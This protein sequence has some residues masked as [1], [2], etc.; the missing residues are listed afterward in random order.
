MRLTA[1]F[2]RPA[3]LPF[4]FALPLLLPIGC[5]SGSSSSG[6]TS[7]ATNTQVSG[8]VGNGAGARPAAR[9]GFFGRAPRPAA[10]FPDAIVEALDSDGNVVASTTTDAAGDYTIS[11]PDGT[12]RLGV[13][14][15]SISSFVPLRSPI[16]VRN[17]T[18]DGTT[19]VSGRATLDFE[20]PDASTT[21]TG[22]VTAS[23]NPV[24]DVN[25][26]FVD[27]E[28]QEVRFS[29]A[30]NGS[31]AFSVS[32]IPVGNF[33]VR[34]A[35]STI[36]TG[37]AAPSARSL[38]VTSGGATPSNFALT[39]PASTSLSGSVDTTN[40][41][42]L[43]LGAAPVGALPVPRPPQRANLV[44][45]D[46]AEVVIIEI[47]I[48]E[49]DRVDMDT[50]GSYVLN[51]RDGSYRLEFVGFGSEVVAPPPLRITVKNGLVYV[52]GQD[53]PIDPS[54]A[55]TLDVLAFDVTASVRG[56]VTVAGSPVRTRVFA[57]DVSTKGVV[58][59]ADT[60]ATGAYTISLADGSYNLVIDDELLPPG[61]IPPDAVRVSIE[62]D[63]NNNT[64][65]REEA[66]TAN[67]GIVNFAM[68]VSSVTLTGTVEDSSQNA[69]K[70]IRVIA[71]KKGERVGRAV[72]TSA[73]AYSLQLPLG[74]VQVGISQESA[75]SG[76]SAP[77]PTVLEVALVNGS[78]VIT[79]SAGEISTLDFTLESRSNNVSGTITF[80]FN[81]DDT[82][83]ANEVVGCRIIVGQPNSKEIVTSTNS[84]PET[85]AY[86]LAVK[87]GAYLI[88]LHPDSLPPGSAP[89]SPRRISVDASGVTTS[90]GTTAATATLD[91]RLSRRASTL[92]GVVT[93]D[94]QAISAGLEL[95]DLS[96]E[97]VAGRARSDSITGIYRLPIFAGRYELR[98]D[99]TTLP[100]GVA[101]PSPITLSATAAGVV[102]T[103]DGTQIDFNDPNN[104]LGVSFPLTR[105]VATLTGAVSV[106]RGSET[107]FVETA[108]EVRDPQDHGVLFSTSSLPG[109]GAYSLKLGAGIWEIGLDPAALPPGVLPPS[110]QVVLVSGTTV[111]GDAV[112]N[113]TLSFVIRD[114]RQAGAAISGLVYGAVSEQGV[115]A[116]LRLFDPKVGSVDEN[117]ILSIRT[118]ED[119][120]YSFRA[121][122]GTYK[123]AVLPDSLPP[124]A[125]PPTSVQLAVRNVNNTATVFETSEAE[126]SGGT[127]NEAD[128]GTINFPIR[129]GSGATTG[130]SIA[131]TVTET[132]GQ[133]SVPLGGVSVRVRDSST[134]DTVARVFTEFGTGTYALR[135]PLGSY[136]LELNP[137]SLPFHLIPRAP[138]SILA[139]LQS[140]V[141]VV[142]TDNGVTVTPNNGVYTFD[143][144]PISA[145][146]T[147]SGT[148]SLPDS[149]AARVFVEL[150]ERSDGRFILGN[151][152]DSAN[153]AYRMQVAP[154]SYRLGID[155][156]SLP[157]G[158]TAPSSVE[159]SVTATA[160]LE[161]SGTA[162]DGTVNF[163]LKSANQKIVGTITDASQEPLACYINVEDAISGKFI[164]GEPT[165]PVTGTYGISVPP[166]TYRVFIDANSLPPGFAP[167]APVKAQV[168][169]GSNFTVDFQ[170]KSDSA[171]IVGDVRQT[172]A[173]QTPMPVFMILED[174]S[175]GQF[176]KGEPNDHE[177]GA[178]K[179]CASDGSYK[180]LVAPESVPF[181]MVV[182]SPVAVQI[183]NGAVLESN[184][185]GNN[186]AADDGTVNFQ[187]VEAA[188]LANSLGQLTG[189]VTLTENGNSSP[190]GT[191]VFVE[192]ATTGQFLNGRP[193]DPADGAYSIFLPVGTYDVLIDTGVLPPGVLPPA[194][195]RIQVKM[196]NNTPT[197]TQQIEGVPVVSNVLDFDLARGGSSISG[198]VTLS[199][200]GIPCFITVIDP[201]T[202]VP[203]NGV[204]T[205]ESGNFSLS[206]G[207]GTYLVGVAPQSLPPGVQPPPVTTVTVSSGFIAES[208]GTANDGILPFTLTQAAATLTVAVQDDASSG[209]FGHVIVKNTADG[210][211]V[212][213]GPSAPDF[214]FV[215]QL[216]DGT[217]DVGIDPPSL[218][219]DVVPPVPSRIQV[220][221]STI[222]LSDAGSGALTNDTLTFTCSRTSQAATVTVRVQD[223]D[224]NPFPGVVRVTDPAG[225]IVMFLPVP[226]DPNGFPLILGDGT[227]AL[228]IDPGS[229]PPGSS[230]PAAQSV[231]I[232]GATA[233]PSS[234]TLVLANEQATLTGNIIGAFSQGNPLVTLD[235]FNGEGVPIRRNLT[236]TPSG[237]DGGYSVDLGEGTYELIVRR[238]EGITAD[239]VIIPKPVKV[240]VSDGNIQNPDAD[241]NTA[242]VQVNVK[243]PTIKATVAGRVTLTGNPIPGVV[244]VARDPVDNKVVNGGTTDSNGDFILALPAGSFQLLPDPGLLVQQAPTALPPDPYPVNVTAAGEVTIPEQ[245]GLC[246]GSGPDEACT[247]LDFALSEFVQ[248]TNAVVAGTIT[249]RN[250]SASAVPVP[251]MKV[252]LIDPVKEAPRS[253]AI[254]DSSGAYSIIAPDGVW[255]VVADPTTATGVNFPTIPAAPVRVSVNGTSIFEDDE[256]GTGNG[257]DDGTV[258]FVLKGATALIQGQ[259]RT[260]NGIGVGCR[261]V[262]TG[263][264]KTQIPDDFTY[265]VF[266]DEIGNFFIPVG[267]GS[268]KLW[269]APESLPPGFLPP[270]PT[271]FTVAG[272]TVTE[273]NTEGSGNQANDGIINPIIPAGGA[274]ISGRVVDGNG[275]GLP[276]FVGLLKPAANANEP[277]FFVTGGPTDPETGD[278]S[279]TAGEGSYFIEM[280]PQSL[281]VGF[282]APARVDLSVTGNTVTFESSATTIDDN[283]TTRVVLTAG[284]A[285]G[286]VTG[287]VLDGQGNPSAANIAVLDA[288]DGRFIRDVFTNPGD[289][290]YSLSLGNGA[291]DLR[292]EP[293]SLPPG[294]LAPPPVR[295]SISGASVTEPNTT[296]TG[297]VA[298]DGIVN[299]TLSGASGQI[300]GFV[301][302]LQGNGVFANVGIFAQD[303]AGNY[304][305]F[306]NGV[307]ADFQT[308]AFQLGVSDGSYKLDVDP[309][310]I[311]PGT[312]TPKPVTISVSTVNSQTTVTYPDDATVENGSVILSLRAA[313]GGVSGSVTLNSS[314]IPAFV[315]AEDPNT[316]Q[317]LGGSPTQ[318]DGSYQISLP[319]GTFDIKIDPFSLPQG[320]SIPAPQRVTVSNTVVEDV[321]FALGQSQAS[322]EGYIL[323][324][325]GPGGSVDP[326]NASIDCSAIS[327]NGNITPVACRIILVIP[328][329]NANTPPTFLGETGS[330][331]ASGYFQLPLGDGTFELHIDGGSLPPG[332]LPPPPVSLSVN[333]ST[334]NITGSVATC[335]D[336][337]NEKIIFLGAG[338]A[339]LNGFVRNASGQGVGAFVEVID[340]TEGH[341]FTGAPTDPTT[342]AFALTLGSQSYDVRIDPFSVPPGT[343][344]PPAVRV[345]QSNGQINVT[346]VDGVTFDNDQLIF[347]LSS[348]SRSISGTIT[349][350]NG[351]PVGAGVQAFDTSDNFRGQIWSDPQNGTYNLGIAPGIY[352]LKIDTFSLPP[353]SAPPPDQT[354]NVVDASVTDVDFTIGSAPA[355]LTGSVYFDDNGQ[356]VGV[357]AFVE[358]TDTSTGAFLGG[359]HASPDGQ[360]DFVYNLSVGA[361]SFKVR[362]APDSLPPGL[363]APQ[364]VSVTVSISSVDG[365]VTISEQAHGND[366]TLDDG[367]ID[368][369][370]AQSGVTLNGRLVDGQQ[371]GIFGFIFL[372]LADGSGA[373]VGEAPTSPSGNFSLPLG[374]GTFR[375]RV[376]PGSLPPTFLAPPPQTVVVSGSS[377]QIGGQTAADP[378]LITISQSSAVLPGTVLKN[379]SEP[380]PGAFV[381]LV[382][383]QTFNFIAGDDADGNGAYTLPLIDGDFQVQVDPFTLPPGF[384]PPLPALI[385]VS[386]GTITR[387][388]QTI[389]SVDFQLSQSLASITVE[390]VDTTGFP[391]F[392]EVELIDQVSGAFLNSR[393]TNGAPVTLDLQEGSFLVLVPPHSLPP[394][395]SAPAPVQVT[396]DSSGNVTD[397][398]GAPDDGFIRLVLQG[399]AVTISGTVTDDSTQ[400]PIPG[401]E[402]VAFDPG[403]DSDIA[404]VFTDGQGQF[405]FGLPVGEFEIEVIGGLPA[406]SVEPAPVLVRV[407]GPG[408]VDPQGSID[409]EVPAASAL[410]SGTV[411]LDGTPVEA[412]VVALEVTG[413]Q[414]EDVSST[415]TDSS[416]AFT[417][418]LPAGDLVLVAELEDPQSQFILPLPVTLSIAQQNPPAQ[419]SQDFAF[420]TVGGQGAPA[421]QMLSGQITAAGAPFD[422]G[423]IVIENG[424]PM[425]LVESESSLYQ[426]ALPAD[427]ARTFDVGIFGA[428]LPSGFTAP[429]PVTLNVDGS[430]IS[431]TGVTPDGQGGF[432]LDFAV[433]VQGVVIQGQVLDASSNPV[434]GVEVFT[435][436]FDPQNGETQ[437]PVKLT[438]ATGQYSLTLTTGEH[439]L[440]LGFGLPDG[441]VRPLPVEIEVS[442]DGNGGFDVTVDGQSTTD[443]T[444]N[445]NL[446]DAVAVLT[447]QVTLGGA[448]AS[449][450]IIA[451]VNDQEV[452]FVEA[453]GGTYTISLPAGDVVV[454]AVGENLP[455]GTL[456]PAPFS[457]TLAD[458]GSLQQLTHDFGFGTIGGST[459][460]A[461]VAGK[462]F[463]N[464]Q[465][466][467]VEIELLDDQGR[468]FGLAE[469]DPGGNFSVNLAVGDYT[470][471]V[472]PG[473]VPQGFA[474]QN[475]FPLE[476][477]DGDFDGPSA[478]EGI[479]YMV[480]NTQGVQISGTVTDP[481]QQPVAGLRLGFFPEPSTGLPP[482]ITATG[483]DG[484][485]QVL[486]T[487]NAS[488]EPGFD[489][490]TLP[491]GVIL[492]T[493]DDVDVVATDIV[494]DVAL[495][496]AAGSIAG[497]ITLDGQPVE[498]EVI[499]VQAGLNALDPEGGIA[500]VTF[501]DS[502]S[503]G[504]YTM[505]LP[506]GTYNVIVDLDL[507]QVQTDVLGPEPR[508]VTITAGTDLTGI[509]FAFTTVGQGT[510]AQVLTGHVLDG[511]TD[512]DAELLIW[513]VGSSTT[514]VF[515]EFDTQ[516]VQGQSQTSEFVY[517]AVLSPGDYLVGIEEIFTQSIDFDPSTFTP[518]AITVTDTQITRDGEPL[519]GNVLDIQI[520]TGPSGLVLAAGAPLTGADIVAFHPLLG[521]TP[522]TVQTDS[523]GEFSFDS[524]TPDSYWVTVSPSSLPQGAALPRLVAVEV[525]DE[526]GAASPAELSIDIPQAAGTLS[527]QVTVDGNGTAGRIF[528]FDR[529][530][531]IVATVATDG[532]GSYQA[533]LAA[534]TYGVV[535]HLD[536]SSGTERAPAAAEVTIPDDTTRDF[537]FTTTAPGATLTGT[538]RIGGELEDSILLVTSGQ[539]PALPAALVSSGSGSQ[540]GQFGVSLADG[541][542]DLRFLPGDSPIN[543]VT[544]E[545]VPLVVTGGAVTST[546]AT[547]HPVISGVLDLDPHGLNDEGAVREVV[548]DV[549][550]AIGDHDA[551]AL[552]TLL[553]ATTLWDGLDRQEILNQWPNSPEWQWDGHRFDH[554]VS[555]VTQISPDE[556][557]VWLTEIR[558]FHLSPSG[559]AVEFFLDSRL[560]GNPAYRL[561][562]RRA[563]AQSPW[564]CAGNGLAFGEVFIEFFSGKFTDSQGDLFEQGVE[565]IL[566]DS[567]GQLQLTGVSVAG[568]G[569]GDGST[570]V[571]LEH[572]TQEGEWYGEAL[573]DGS[574]DPQSF[575][576]TFSQFVAGS[577][578]TVDVTPQSGSPES[579]TLRYEEAVNGLY[580]EV[581]VQPLQDGSV[582]VS[583]DDITHQLDFSV[584]DIELEITQV[585]G[586]GPEIPVLELSELSPGTSW[587]IL[588]AN[589][590]TNGNVYTFEVE[591]IDNGGAV[592]SH[593]LQM[594]WPPQLP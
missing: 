387:N 36:P 332:V 51:L 156:N 338:G 114:V 333:G 465:G 267:E 103:P 191:F 532:S 15:G 274:T 549:L 160:V 81:G 95:Y 400:Q 352:T 504:A 430:G 104:I 148:V 150:R 514:D 297:N 484:T 253:S 505:F 121:A 278:F 304:S 60:D 395:L 529:A 252:L 233:T 230:L 399:S 460:G 318:P 215:I 286:L 496:D 262:V 269:T 448:P 108:V 163:T 444:V 351:N 550:E 397:G 495:Q 91:F 234:I 242:G 364:P 342:G 22:T 244:V 270:S 220:S 330:D 61:V 116:E 369:E 452:T 474:G 45:P 394:D 463:S 6:G 308:G 101:V 503:G 551:T 423:I 435:I 154:G 518:I 92:S 360:G 30:T 383:S 543:V 439:E 8:N 1:P 412:H 25:V 416:G 468:V 43:T 546:N 224:S 217:Y 119:G 556:Y 582:L 566:E 553:D 228:S 447:G 212:A 239:Q 524:L 525:G 314:G 179:L 123:L 168:V 202:G 594:S 315:F 306:V 129:L 59:R 172:D 16:I 133:Q 240:T 87:N 85:G 7:G 131:G 341:F 461:L 118:A 370:L 227:Y 57:Q 151:W 591:Y 282:Q 12:Y 285:S 47:G 109:T 568:A 94:S 409:I 276:V 456:P 486:V 194:R 83:D 135:L 569:I 2:L 537:A 236:L 516:L 58:A 535:A 403:S 241:S 373:I 357:A 96:R 98:L 152:T 321:D 371:N 379:G 375:L 331:P 258:N 313:A 201:V 55:G 294:M 211:R 471:R 450:E 388:G 573:S 198:S 421:S 29:T 454:F 559:H 469:T 259:V 358:I 368:F 552:G 432:D 401:A 187:I 317:F 24:A 398:S 302:D 477:L 407:L 136:L 158:L 480:L 124:N 49:V 488:Y 434:P 570:P 183:K 218:P 141:V 153:G 221:G 323:L 575:T 296:G 166:G 544:P 100:P 451:R 222:T 346:T 90:D 564:L 246:T 511:D 303:S 120:T 213:E 205:D 554:V 424:N 254:T 115:K 548:S 223:S 93:V 155:P 71:T 425:A 487:G 324:P 354:V 489:T 344:T 578:Y 562:V 48:G 75:P 419:I 300:T 523:A 128:D 502:D 571:A 232:S 385:N 381:A 359:S 336:D 65:V 493:L 376:D 515:G 581:E 567:Q 422:A 69:L 473:E 40:G 528:F 540:L 533:P 139:S 143:L 326:D 210:Q 169:S 337:A 309:G 392:S 526:D 590:L 173:G 501:V 538:V 415:D 265:T 37:F 406:G 441:V 542:Y 272:S 14:R 250:G 182:P 67:D 199:S 203:V 520:S 73:G 339:T 273:N 475:A 192:D 353:G 374:D 382:D 585:P 295:V 322:F 361:G 268:F 588:P 288:S 225:N 563:D 534:G 396:V 107:F 391:I 126:P 111:S 365:S 208:A 105:S 478:D 174:A 23:G 184:T 557:V 70:D 130:I 289:G 247:G 275:N 348:A 312:L 284:Q 209:L 545:P 226:A 410:V 413:Q 436:T 349:D 142:T 428:E 219:F 491:A 539:D 287:T 593:V 438:N 380:V 541:S 500:E 485:Y 18:V 290:Q 137:D 440:E 147:L 19:T 492:P 79:S 264:E 356:D 138:K 350:S 479:F 20:V 38:A 188:D 345:S 207:N 134:G 483:Q 216:G 283:G 78:P 512:L 527:G 414:I 279:F 442:D 157:P 53:D 565:V 77:D 9:I 102:T 52:E 576:A 561:I 519:G 266:T 310:S 127:A 32:V 574:S 106:T 589:T 41:S 584:S 122:E 237:N 249:A 319:A 206:L 181:G 437:G 50:D 429:P 426:M 255:F 443:G 245:N 307:P 88:G 449:A 231:S 494:L 113:G 17:G 171:C 66:G 186:N 248:G 167:P 63:G 293:F 343:S 10:V 195:V 481:S 476:V 235:L 149:G 140:N 433:S 97:L 46:G 170:V 33:T 522:V 178:F 586:Q 405:S 521:I 214:N 34:L 89:P 177:T 54:A 355:S 386:G 402:V 328:A 509:D 363:I 464:G 445:W 112:T 261:L 263:A 457:S 453:S 572:D 472:Y 229:V 384:T 260:S 298:D 292:I 74:T 577:D 31:G 592:H 507:S 311:P 80:D 251:G 125:V 196:V 82:I 583:W 117:F 420:F 510:V 291:Y 256:T 161:S 498:A 200:T 159:V 362:V 408:Q 466:L 243:I 86:S 508:R 547:D 499:S 367:V 390:V 162:D 431:G 325:S 580:P 176:I 271:V 193:T 11:L 44:V 446:Q 84:D 327:S 164:R 329:S 146:Q 62:S 277:P 404:R 389:T 238:A 3:I 467:E 204:P 531:R 393:F 417:L 506:E 13:R 334:V 39:L 76:L 64:T 587:V 470:L 558:E 377:I 490:D 555:E 320:L 5:H 197:I 482:V 427:Q 21:V 560:T 459:P 411:T 316:F 144:N 28:T 517:R 175:T 165:N 27:P 189:T 180:L 26:E 257:L 579:Y 530:L 497:T 458:T 68:S 190:V 110:P 299:F 418:A 185:T 72:T 99:P 378:H 132:V 35:P 301:R 372:E 42:S 462:V 281:P 513:K 280:D 145:S 340:P 536:Q 4:L 335:T 455:Q 366:N 347:T 305:I 56:T